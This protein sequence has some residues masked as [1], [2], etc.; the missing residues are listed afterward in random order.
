MSESIKEV[1][2]RRDNMTGGAVVIFTSYSGW[3][4]TID[5]AFVVFVSKTIKDWKQN[6][7]RNYE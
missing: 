7:Q 3:L 1:L 5:I 6:V 2:M 4:F